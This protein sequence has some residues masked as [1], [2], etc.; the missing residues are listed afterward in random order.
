MSSLQM[1]TGKNAIRRSFSDVRDV[2]PVPNLIEVQSKSFN[3]FVQ[4]DYLSSERQDIGLQKVLKDIFPVEYNGKM[5]LEFISYELGNWACTCGKLK[6]IENRYAWYCASTK[7]SGVSCLATDKTAPKKARYK[8]CASCLSRVT[9]Q[10]P[11]TVDECRANGQ[12]FSM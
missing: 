3:D 5:S 11:M 4:L 8:T 1:G 2:V 6:G 9:I 7:K 10:L 12:T